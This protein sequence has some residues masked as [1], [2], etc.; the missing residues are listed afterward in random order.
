[1]H[2]GR[3]WRVCVGDCGGCVGV[4]GGYVKVDGVC[5]V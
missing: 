3:V 2:V 4:C 5:Y 1:M